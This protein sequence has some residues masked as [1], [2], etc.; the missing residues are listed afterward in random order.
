MLYVYMRVMLE[1]DYIR[2]KHHI[3]M[4]NPCMAEKII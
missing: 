3:I 4:Q 2:F 1:S